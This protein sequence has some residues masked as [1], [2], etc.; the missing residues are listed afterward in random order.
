MVPL[1]RS[2]NAVVSTAPA[3]VPC[4]NVFASSKLPQVILPMTSTTRFF[5]VRLLTVARHRFGQISKQALPR[6]AVF[7]TVSRN[8]RTRLFGSAAQPSVQ[9]RSLRNGRQP[10]RTWCT[11]QSASMRSRCHLTTPASPQ[12]CRNQ[13]GPGH[14]GNQAVPFHSYFI[15]LHL[16]QIQVSWKDN[17][18]RHLLAVLSRSLLPVCHRSLIHS[19]GMHKGLGRTSLGQERDHDHHQCCRRAQPF[20]HGSL[21]RTTSLLTPATAITGW[22]VRMNPNRARSDLASCGARPSGAKLL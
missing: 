17:G 4:S 21:A 8:A 20:H 14:P 6:P 22:L 3:R 2:L 10:A 18:F 5:S 1:T 19:R 13:Q 7:F 12:T 11:K 15:G 9:T 16:V